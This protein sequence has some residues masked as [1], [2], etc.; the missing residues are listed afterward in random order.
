[1]KK[2]MFVKLLAVLAVMLVLPACGK[3]E[4][5]WKD[6]DVEFAPEMLCHV[7]DNTLNQGQ[8]A[9]AKNK[10]LFHRSKLT[11]DLHLQPGVPALGDAVMEVKD[12]K[13]TLD[14]ETGR[15][16][17]KT[18]VTSNLRVTDLNATIDFNEQSMTIYYTVD[19]RYRVMSTMTEVFYL[20]NSSTLNYDNGKSSNDGASVYMFDIDPLSMTATMKVAPLTNTQAVLLFENIIA[21][22][23]SVE[24]T[25]DGYN[26]KADS[27][28][29]VSI[30]NRID[31]S[32][33][34]LTT[35]DAPDEKTGRQLYPMKNMSAHLSLADG[36]H[37]TT[38]T[39]GSLAD[40]THPFTVNAKG[41]FYGDSKIK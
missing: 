1:M 14:E 17:V 24:I 30:L 33:G 41:V 39:M 9:N 8:V 29:V 11:A 12:L 31:P 26:L 35:I 18:S 3:D 28:L 13:V 23:I 16:S 34:T 7:Y 32:A 10:L 40:G 22:G 2:K 38:F 19:G 25:K 36:A 4:P 6:R 27:P 15:Y 20:S 21:R 5:G 37:T